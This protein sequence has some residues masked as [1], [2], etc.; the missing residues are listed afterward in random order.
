[1]RAAHNGDFFFAVLERRNGIGDDIMMLH[2]GHR[3]VDACHLRDL[4]RIAARRIDND[5]RADRSLFC[6]NIP[7]ARWQLG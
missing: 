7:F 2:I 4:P 5:F 3:N 6:L 1:M